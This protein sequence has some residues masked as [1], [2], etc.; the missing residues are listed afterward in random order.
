MARPTKYDSKVHPQLA[1]AWAAAGKI[2]T[3]IAE[4]LGIAEST[5]R[6][7]EKRHKAFSAALKSGRSPSDDRVERSLFERAIGYSNPNAVKIFLPQGSTEPIYAPYTEH[8]PPEVVA[9]IF[10]LKNRRPEKW[11]DKQE[12]DHNMTSVVYESLI[13]DAS[14]TGR[15]G[16]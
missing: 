4:K 16:S 13:P 14:D 9:C 2:N 7:W 3:E 1:E 11:R 10:W 12:L 15:Q 8:Y 5:L 6:L